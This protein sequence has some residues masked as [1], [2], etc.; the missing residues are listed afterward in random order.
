MTY[1]KSCISHIHTDG[2]RGCKTVR[3]DTAE[4]ES[5][6]NAE[7]DH[8]RETYQV[9]T[10]RLASSEV[11]RDVSRARLLRQQGRDHWKRKAARSSLAGDLVHLAVRSRVQS[12]EEGREGSY[13]LEALQE[14]HW[15]DHSE[16]TVGGLEGIQRVVDRF[17]ENICLHGSPPG[18][19]RPMPGGGMPPG[20][21]GGIPPGPPGGPI[22]PG[23]GNGPGGGILFART[24]SNIS[25][26][27]ILV[28][29]EIAHDHPRHQEEGHQ[30][31]W[32][33]HRSLA[34]QEVPSVA[35]QTRSHQEGVLRR[36]RM[37]P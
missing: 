29:N 25:K 2:I 13:R 28:K 1:S 6:H 34:A 22:M 23:G 12:L 31:P 9:I 33:D 26:G 18:P 35:D 32:A 17:L 10:Y 27:Q 14:G 19:G 4:I 36:F 7:G 5:E 20:G 37:R 8:L 24:A 30:S 21:N 11:D 16:G 3:C 15:A